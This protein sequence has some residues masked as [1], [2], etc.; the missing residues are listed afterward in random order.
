MHH[1]LPYKKTAYGNA[2]SFLFLFYGQF[3]DHK[4]VWPVNDFNGT[5]YGHPMIFMFFLNFF[6]IN[7]F[8]YFGYLVSSNSL[9]MGMP[10]SN[11]QSLLFRV[12]ARKERLVAFS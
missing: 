8:Q 2:I 6:L 11:F 5:L 9:P 7:N 3:V 12:F 1:K 4:V 10:V